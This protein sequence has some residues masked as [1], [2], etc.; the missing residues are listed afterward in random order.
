MS[1]HG[2]DGMMR[3]FLG[4][5]GLTP[6][7]KLLKREKYHEDFEILKLCIKYCY[8]V[9]EGHEDLQMFG[10]KPENIGKGH[11]EGWGKGKIHLFRIDEIVMRESTR[12]KLNLDDHLMY[13]MLW[14]HVDPE[15]DE[16]IE[17]S[18]EEMYMSDEEDAE[19]REEMKAEKLREELLVEGREMIRKDYR[20]Q[21]KRRKQ[22]RI[23]KEH[24]RELAAEAAA[25]GMRKNFNWAA[26][27]EKDDK[28]IAWLLDEVKVARVINITTMELN[29]GEKAPDA[30]DYSDI[31][32]DAYLPEDEIVWEYEACSSD[33][34]GSSQ[35]SSRIDRMLANLHP[36][37]IPD[38]DTEYDAWDAL[39]E[40]DG[41]SETSDDDDDM[42]N[43]SLVHDTRD[44]GAIERSGWWKNQKWAE[45][46]PKPVSEDEFGEKVEDDEWWA[47]SSGEEG[48]GED[49]DDDDDD[50]DD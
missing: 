24:K 18:Y 45:S 48:D 42:P 49:D 39:H 6:L 33:C 34:S 4:Q 44:S 10:I 26:Q 30:V 50:D 2:D 29:P 40:F 43:Q 19:R 20:E 12:R 28:L 46:E 25:R 35:T 14:G 47:T 8:D 27:K 11:L 16:N 23:V 5:R 21:K 15:T 9:K 37:N 7:C 41:A 13:M 32:D 3:V 1:Q 17:P 22:E 31:A 36:P 38:S